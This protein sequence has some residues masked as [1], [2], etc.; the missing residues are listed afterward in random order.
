MFK[1][2]SE[3]RAIAELGSF[4]LTRKYLQRALPKGDGH[5]LVIIPGF[6][7]GD[8]FTRSLR[9]LLR[10]LGYDSHPWDQGV[11]QGLRDE[12]CHNIERRIAQIHRE[13]GRKVS[14]IGHSLGGVYVRA[15]AHRQPQHVRQII[16]LGSPFNAS[17]DQQATDSKGGALARAYEQLN[18]GVENDALPRSNLMSFPPQLPSTSVYSEGDG[19]VGWQHCMDIADG[20]TENVRI[21]GSH[22]GM[23]HNPLVAYVIADRLAQNENEWR[24]FDPRGVEKLLLKPACITELFPEWALDDQPAV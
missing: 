20:L 5:P 6:M 11:N 24:P 17:F 9:R 14:L 2:A 23:A 8:A 22:T 7:I 13:S 4:F 18:P 21:P 19:I 15:I 16:T 3:F 10:T 12:T 1:T